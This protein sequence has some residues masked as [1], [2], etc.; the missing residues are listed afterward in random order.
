MAS[1]Q[2]LDD[3]DDFDW[4][5]AVREIDVV[6]NQATTNKL[7]E[8]PFGSCNLPPMAS[9]SCPNKIENNKPSSSR[10]STLDRFIGFTGLKSS[11]QD[12]KHDAKEN[13]ERDNGCVS[14][15]S[16]DPEAAKTWIYPENVPVRDYQVS[17][18]RTALFSN[19][20]V[21]LPTGLGKTLIA[22]VVMYNYFRWFPEGK[23]VFTAPSRPLVVQQIAACHNIVGIPQEWTVDMTGQ[24]PPAKRVDLWKVKRIF[25]VTPQVLEKDIQSGKSLESDSLLME[26]VNTGSCVVKQLVCLVIDEAHHATGNASSCVAV[27]ELMA[28]PV[29]LRILALT[30]TP[31]S[32]HENVQQ[33]IDNLQISSLEHRSESDPDVSPYVHERKV[34]V[35]QVAM[36]KDA[37]EA[38]SLL[39]DV[40]RPFVARLSSMGVDLK[41]RKDIQTFSPHEILESRDEFRKKRPHDLPEPKNQ[42]IEKIFGYLITL[43]H[44]RKLLSAHGI[45]PAYEMLEDKLKQGTL[46]RL[47]SN[48]G[49]QKVERMMKE[50]VSHGAL[51][52][53]FT[54]MI[55]VLIEHFKTQDPEKSRVIIFSNFR[56]SVRDIMNSLATIGPFV[57][58]TEFI[59]Q[60]TGKKSKGQSQ[61]AQ[62]RVLQDFQAGR[63]NVIVATSIAE[64]GLDI[65]EVNLVICFDA[66][67]SPLRMI[68]RMGRTGRKNAGRVDILLSCLKVLFGILVLACEGSEYKGY[69]R[70]Q[71]NGKTIKKHMLNGGMHSFNFHSSPR[72]VPHVFR[73]EKRLVKLLI[74]EY[75]PRGK[76]VKEDDGIQTPKYKAKLT[77]AE[78]DLIAKYFD[79]CRENNWRPSLIAFPHFQ[80]FPSRVHEVAHSMRTMMLIDTMQC[81]QELPFSNHDESFNGQDEEALEECFEVESVEHHN[82]NTREDDAAREEPETDIFRTPP[83]PRR[84]TI[85]ILP[86]TP[87]CL[88]RI[89]C[90]LTHMETFLFFTRGEYPETALDVRSHGNDDVVT[91]LKKTNDLQEDKAAGEHRVI[92][93]EISNMELS[94]RELNTGENL[95]A[96]VD[97]SHS[98]DES[99]NDSRAGT[100]SKVKGNFTT[101][102][103]D[104]LPDDPI[105]LVQSKNDDEAEESTPNRGN[106]AALCMQGEMQ[107]PRINLISSSSEKGISVSKCKG[108]IRTPVTNIFDD[109]SCSKD[110]ILTSGEKS[111]SGPKHRLKRLRKYGDTKSRN[112]SDKEEFVGHTSV[113]GARLDRKSYKHGRGEK[114]LVDDAKVFIEDEAEVS[115]GASGDEDVDNG[116][117]SYEGSFIDDRINPTVASTQAE[118]SE[119]DMMAIYRRSLLSQ[120]PIQRSSHLSM[121]VSPDSGVPMDQMHDSGSAF[122]IT[123][124]SLHHSH[125]STNGDSSSIPLNTEG[126]SST[127]M[128]GVR[129]RKLSFSQGGS[130]PIRNLEKEVF[131]KPEAGGENPTWQMEGGN[132][133]A[134]ED[135]DEFYQGIDLDALEEEATKQL[136]SKSESMNEK[137]NNQNLEMLDCPSFDLGI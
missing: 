39:M 29:Q 35:I 53:K 111:V 121:D 44:I 130:P 108:E 30:A 117:D 75:V 109:N 14:S 128:N 31:G 43:Y 136:R 133:D 104:M 40:I 20:L 42:E 135:D 122:G 124:P 8:A 113:S 59:G 125:T 61:K 126:L 60:N 77:D 66:N 51:S 112:L 63:F 15:V 134:F 22:A 78:T 83:E 19:T 46:A 32:K 80:A 2:T 33:V 23:I 116:Q 6:C 69:M 36:G 49:L 81:L 27:R 1:I 26:I 103:V 102:D 88:V 90:R 54:K 123:N 3:D 95:C 131:L 17:I 92:Q 101:P 110:W 79:P 93:T 105:T 118:A 89:L 52:P 100:L 37:L 107:T 16:I 62:Q 71:A 4:D 7:E 50:S 106:V 73:P 87:F 119:C 137:P 115:S 132:M 82:S 12:V 86:S 24:T 96:V 34:E 64:E 21:S 67:I 114:K 84:N 72:M 28:V 91:S 56:G 68:Q 58:A 45:E 129:K 94:D 47:R 57:K 99:N 38:N 41:A 85:K 13:S 25:F 74:E 120:T 5:A 10:Q 65:M 70:K 76:K 127:T 98:A 48:V 9:S 55:E 18:T 11:N 97:D